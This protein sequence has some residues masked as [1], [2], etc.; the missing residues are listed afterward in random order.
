MLNILFFVS[1]FSYFVATMLQFSFSAFKKGILRKFSWIMAL[2]GF[3]LLSGYIIVR[4]IV[5]GRLPLSNQFEFASGFAWGIGLLHIVL[6]IRFKEDWINTVAVPA[7][8][9]ILSYAAI[10]P[11]EINPMMPAL[12]SIWFGLHIG[13]AVFS[14]ASFMI[15]G[16]IGVR[17]ILLAKRND[18]EK[19][20]A[21]LD[22]MSYRLISFGFLLLTV[23]ILSGCIWAEQAWSTFWSWDPKETWALITWFVYA[24]YLHQR[25]RRYKKGVRMAW[26]A[27]IAVICVLFTF[28]G[29]N[30]LLP[31]L[32]S[33]A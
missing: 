11:R 28:I 13:S 8:F 26:F 32:H 7:A 27:V 9:L 24:I 4:G 5:A 25:L 15:A 30:L 14:Y 31:G 6:V 12:K 18:N 29:V 2:I 17:Y 1:L 23:V 20:L 21:R 16:C 19:H 10:L 22:L 3:V 33:Y